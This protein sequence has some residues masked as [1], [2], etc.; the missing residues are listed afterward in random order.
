MSISNGPLLVRLLLRDG[1]YAQEF[2]ALDSRG[3]YR[4]VLSSIHK[5]L[6]PFSEH[7][8][9]ASPM[10]AGGRQHLFAVCR[11]S[12]RMVFS[13]V[14]LRR[15]SQ[16]RVV[17]E[18]RGSVQGHELTMRMAIETGSN[19]V[20]VTVEDTPPDV[21]IEYLMSSYAFVPDGRVLEVDN[22]PPVTWAPCMRP[23][24]DAV[25][26]DAAF[27]SPA[28]VVQQDRFAAALIPDIDLLARHRPMPAALDLDLKNGLLFAPL[29]SYGFCDY[30]RAKDR[31]RHDVTHSRV[32]GVDRLTYGFHLIVDADC[33]SR[34][35]CGQIARF[36]WNRHGD[37]AAPSPQPSPPAERVLQ[38]AVRIPPSA[39]PAD[40]RAAYGLWAE[41]LF[42]G[43][44]ELIRQ[45]RAMRG[46]VLAAEDDGLFV[47]RFEGPESACYSTV[48]CSEQLCWLLRLH[49]D[50]ES[51]ERILHVVERYAGVLIAN[52]AKSGAIPCWL[53]QD[54][55]VVPALRSGAPTAASAV[56]LAEMARITGKREYLAAFELS[57]RFVMRE[58]V[59][60]GLYIDYT[61]VEEPAD[62]H[63]GMRTQ[64]TRAMLWVAQLCLEMH[65]AFGEAG[66][67][68]QGAEVL[69][70]ACL[71]Q[72][73][74]EKPWMDNRPGLVS[75]GN[76]AP[77][78][79]PELSADFA[80]CAMRYGAATGVEEYSQRGAAALRAALAAECDDVATARVAAAAAVARDEFASAALR[81]APQT[82]ATQGLRGKAQRATQSR[83]TQGS[84]KRA[85]R[86][87]RVSVS[88]ASGG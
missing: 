57:A 59:P 23:A 77:V 22:D 30:E 73:V 51:D 15:P 70:L 49:F 84:R 87:S 58:V 41:G 75:R 32:L 74:G 16:D 79:D 65:S 21:A 61:C 20:H 42:N 24:G 10:I 31:F 34:P 36:L 29:L 25:I 85:V 19:A 50:M 8:A 3:E 26:G 71:A 55:T 54:R 28:A 78:P 66:Y 13:D 86:G 6:I 18:L 82:G 1:G 48:E 14:R 62:P 35:A 17:V 68:R 47:T 69:D 9:C 80:L 60:Q 72:S 88:R 63:T 33:R 39:F 27:F 12:L 67:L 37:G 44:Q 4:L 43:R 52:R 45:A 2:H 83:A 53:A 46:A 11:E 7:R 76:C 40:A 64:S 5:E 81:Y 56:F 38:S